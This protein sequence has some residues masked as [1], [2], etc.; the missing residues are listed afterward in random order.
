MR[1]M[2]FGPRGE[3]IIVN[4]YLSLERERRV[5]VLSVTWLD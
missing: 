3:G 5:V 1:K 2:L 4:G